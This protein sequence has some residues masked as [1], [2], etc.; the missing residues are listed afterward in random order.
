[1]NLRYSYYINLYYIGCDNLGYW[2]YL[3]N[4]EDY[5][6]WLLSVIKYNLNR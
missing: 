4:K 5:G 3:K 6:Y 1:M 2:I